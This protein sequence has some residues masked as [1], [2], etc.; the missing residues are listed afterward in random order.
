MTETF[1]SLK[2]V[3]M[4]AGLQSLA[5]TC[6]LI[7]GPGSSFRT[8]NEQ[9]P[10]KH[11]SITYQRPSRTEVVA[12]VDHEGITAAMLIILLIAADLVEGA[13]AGIQHFNIP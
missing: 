7:L 11:D 12:M 2:I 3:V 6:V 4:Y 13:S 1:V 10:N 5:T 8:S 9:G